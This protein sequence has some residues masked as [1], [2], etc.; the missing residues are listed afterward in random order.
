MLFIVYHSVLDYV[1]VNVVVVPVHT[2]KLI[3]IRC[4]MDNYMIFY[5]GKQRID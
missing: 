4:T 5:R 3:I 2:R 1:P